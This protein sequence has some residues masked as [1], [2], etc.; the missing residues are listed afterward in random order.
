MD[1]NKEVQSKDKEIIDLKIEMADLDRQ[2]AEKDLEV[3]QIKV[4]LQKKKA[5][6]EDTQRR[7]EVV[8][9]DLQNACLARNN[10]KFDLKVAQD[11]ITNLEK[12]VALRD[13]HI[14]K[15]RE[16]NLK[17]FQEMNASLSVKDRRMVELYKDVMALMD[18]ANGL[19]SQLDEAKSIVMHRY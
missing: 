6:T 2:I 5:E 9:N 1:K 7:Q 16:K 11:Q 12:K 18:K 4:A 13:A 19:S 10:L 8:L 14:A 3:N 17:A 15:E